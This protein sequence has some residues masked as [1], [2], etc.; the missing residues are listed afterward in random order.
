[1]KPDSSREAKKV[2][3]DE[4]SMVCLDSR[5]EVNCGLHNVWS[6]IIHVGL[7]EPWSVAEL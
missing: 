2:I 6:A 7:R 4:L 1:M 5:P 3:K